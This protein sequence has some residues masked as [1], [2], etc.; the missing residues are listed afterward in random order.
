MGMNNGKKLKIQFAQKL[1]GAGLNSVLAYAASFILA[2]VPPVVCEC[3][4]MDFY[5]SVKK[6]IDSLIHH[7]Q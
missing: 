7:E 3:V 6:S 4:L 1:K 2:G 5:C